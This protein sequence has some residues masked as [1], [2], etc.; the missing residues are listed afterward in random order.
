MKIKRPNKNRNN[1]VRHKRVKGRRLPKPRKTKADP[2]GNLFGGTTVTIAA[3]PGDLRAA[4]ETLDDALRLHGI[5]GEDAFYLVAFAYV[6]AQP[7]ARRDGYERIVRRGD[8]IL[9]RIE[10]TNAATV[11]KDCVGLDPNGDELPNWYQHFVGRR[12]RE[13]S[14]KFFT[15]RPVA[16]AMAAL[17]PCTAGAVIMDP[18]CGGGTFLLEASRKWGSQPCT[19]VAN[20]VEASLVDLC[21]LVLGLSIDASGRSRMYSTSNIYQPLKELTTWAGRVDV[22][23]ANPPFSLPIE[24][25]TTPSKLF[26]MGY[27]NSDAIFIDVCHALLRE[28]GR[29]VSLF[30]HSIVANPEFDKLRRAVSESWGVLGVIGLPEGVFN[31]TASTTTRAD[32]V[33]LEKRASR[34]QR[35]TRVFA[36]AASAGVPLNGRKRTRVEND[37]ERITSDTSVLAAM[38]DG[39]TT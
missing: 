38:N 20:D 33:I 32:I 10:D 8:P 26:E 2:T 29:L 27:R 34:A 14:G 31:M 19:L 13:G 12:Y 11:L 15:P 7:K 6:L 21:Q 35:R 22:I 24:S 36:F 16:R 5:E 30:P 25:L 37:L 17:T 39:V 18:T 23:L 28:G 3:R 9:R 4:R 1:G